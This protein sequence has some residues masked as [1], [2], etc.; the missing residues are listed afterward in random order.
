MTILPERKISNHTVEFRNIVDS[1]AGEKFIMLNSK[2]LADTVVDLL[3]SPE[4]VQKAKEEIAAALEG[5]LWRSGR[6]IRQII[7]K[8]AANAAFLIARAYFGQTY[9]GRPGCVYRTRL[10]LPGS[11][12]CKPYNAYMPCPI[13]ACHFHMNIVQW[14]LPGAL[15][16]GNTRFLDIKFLCMH[17]HRIECIIDKAAA[18]SIPP[19]NRWLRESVA[20]PNHVRRLGNFAL[21]PAKKNQCLFFCG[22]GKQGDIVF[23]HNDGITTAKIHMFGT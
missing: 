2:T 18:Q 11:D 10:P 13:P 23:R 22:R 5:A 16:A 17:K 15:P 21:C 20:K 7:K 12:R 14:T 9:R 6:K 8:K 3:L 1:P 4:A 19:T